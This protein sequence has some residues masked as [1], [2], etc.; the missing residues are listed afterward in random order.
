MHLLIQIKNKVKLEE[1]NESLE[2]NDHETM[3]KNSSEEGM[4]TVRSLLKYIFSFFTLWFKPRHNVSPLNQNHPH[5]SLKR[6]C[7][8]NKTFLI[9]SAFP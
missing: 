1:D 4:Y 6:A 9:A 5:V 2:Q 8:K 7:Y 3:E